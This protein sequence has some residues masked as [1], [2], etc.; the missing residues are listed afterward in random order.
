MLLFAMIQACEKENVILER[1]YPRVDIL[2]GVSQNESGMGFEAKFLTQNDEILDKGFV[3]NIT[4]TPFLHNSP[5]IT[6]GEGYEDGSFRGT[7]C[8]NFVAGTEYRVRA[9]AVTA[10]KTI[11]SR[12]IMFVCE[13]SCN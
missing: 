8:E 13:R 6:V 3:W 9:Y 10:E 11:Y 4:T 2:D 12:T 5:Y 7:A 1:D